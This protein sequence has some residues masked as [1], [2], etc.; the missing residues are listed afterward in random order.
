M[1]GRYAGAGAAH[2][3]HQPLAARQLRQRTAACN[4]VAVLSRQDRR[5][6]SARIAMRAAA[7]LPASY[8]TGCAAAP[9]AGA[10]ADCLA[11]EDHNVRTSAVELLVRIGDSAAPFSALI[12]ASVNDS[13]WN[14]CF[15]AVRALGGLVSHPSFSARA[16]SQL[17]LRLSPHCAPHRVWL[18]GVAAAAHA[19]EIAQ[20]VEHEDSDVQW[21]AL[22]ALGNMGAASEPYGA[23]IALKLQN[24]DERVRRA[25]VLALGDN[26]S[27]CEGCNV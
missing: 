8:L 5:S 12:A 10:V 26:P 18:Q 20:L 21:A 25:A 19:A 24:G 14:V 17:V 1:G 13:D 16:T 23:Q 3:L 15:L 22:E 11:D 9:C 7:H 27:A 2:Q 4:G 6:D